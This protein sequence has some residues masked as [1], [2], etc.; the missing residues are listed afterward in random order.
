MN[1]HMGI[2]RRISFF[3]K[4]QDKDFISRIA[5]KLNALEYKQNDL[6]WD[7][8]ENSD[9]STDIIKKLIFSLF[10]AVRTGQNGD[11][12]ESDDF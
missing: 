10:H 9:A 1:F 2:M 4:C 7:T 8:N 11:R 12:A 3:T 5:S 6:I